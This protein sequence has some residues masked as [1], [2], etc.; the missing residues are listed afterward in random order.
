MKNPNKTRRYK[1][2][3]GEKMRRVFRE[4]LLVGFEGGGIGNGGCRFLCVERYR[5]WEI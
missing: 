5:C 4:N 3:S 1:M 2:I